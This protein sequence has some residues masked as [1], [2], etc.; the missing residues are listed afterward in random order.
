MSAWPRPTPQPTTATATLR[1]AEWAFD[2]AVIVTVVG[3]SAS[4]TVDGFTE[5]T[6]CGVGRS[7][8]SVMVM[9]ADLRPSGPVPWNVIVSLSSQAVSERGC[10]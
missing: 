8:S 6:T 10:M 4:L 9:V 2:D 1:D 3:P 7:P 5:R